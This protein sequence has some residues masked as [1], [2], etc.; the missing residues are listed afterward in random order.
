[1]QDFPMI[2]S[3][4][5]ERLKFARRVRDNKEKGFAF[6]EG[7][8]LCEEAIRSRI[9]IKT[10]F[11]TKEFGHQELGS[12][13]D[14]FL[15]N[16]STDVFIV[17]E[18][19]LTSISDTKTPQGILMI[20]V[21]PESTPI[22][23]LLVSV[24]SKLRIWVALYKVNNPS[25]LGAVIRTAEAAGV[26]GLIISAGSADPFSAKSLRA[27]MGSAFRL[28]IALESELEICIEKAKKYRILSAAID[29]GGT[30]G[31][32]LFDW[33]RPTL[34]VFGSEAFGLTEK[35]NSQV[36]AKVKIEMAPNVE[37]L[38][39]AVSSGIVLFEARRQILRLS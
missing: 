35:L 33:K 2:T 25:N 8:R 9:D 17:S 23:S 3:R 19:I 14:A 16:G 7:R 12:R 26:C 36:D 11:V 38:N 6:I 22:D 15:N 27:S 39:L 10:A 18:S 28:P 31:H 37:S 32:T 20:G 1:M 4:D 21:R 24:D 5:N 34:L 13:I 29:A 30:V